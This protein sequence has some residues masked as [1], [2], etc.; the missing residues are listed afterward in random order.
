MDGRILGKFYGMKL[1]DALGITSFHTNLSTAK[2][3]LKR[4]YK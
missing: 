1:K 4:V 3:A 2:Q